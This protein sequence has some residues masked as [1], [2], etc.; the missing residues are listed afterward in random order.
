MCRPLRPNGG[1]RHGGRAWL[2][3][4]CG[5]R[6]GEMESVEEETAVDGVSRGGSREWR[7]MKWR[8]MGERRGEWIGLMEAQRVG[9]RGGPGARGSVKGGHHALPCDVLRGSSTA[10]W[11]GDKAH[12]CHGFGS[13]TALICVLVS[14]GT[15]WKDSGGNVQESHKSSAL[16][17]VL[18]SMNLTVVSSRTTTR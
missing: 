9:W 3:D 10:R 12:E 18:S 7:W 1:R 13:K 14:L 17:R 8:A 16:A 11:Q 5:G 4:R 2:N 6:A 15:F